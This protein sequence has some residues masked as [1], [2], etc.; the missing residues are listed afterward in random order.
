MTEGRI[1]KFVY[2]PGHIFSFIKSRSL[3]IRH[4]VPFTVGP[5]KE[6]LP[7]NLGSQHVVALGSSFISCSTLDK[8]PGVRPPSF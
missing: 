7:S 3:D 5:G 6:S 8:F 2:V 4:H 1:L